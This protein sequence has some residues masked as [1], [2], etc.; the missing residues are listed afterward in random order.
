MDEI[1][2]GPLPDV[3]RVVPGGDRRGHAVPKQVLVVGIGTLAGGQ[4]PDLSQFPRS[5]NSSNCAPSQSSNPGGMLSPTAAIS[6]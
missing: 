5:F 2:L 6:W 1:A 4:S 3:P